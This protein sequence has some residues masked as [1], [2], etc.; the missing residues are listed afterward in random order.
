MT[1]TFN[2]NSDMPDLWRIE[3]IT[4][5]DGTDRTDGHY[6]SR[7]GCIVAILYIKIGRP[8]LWSYVAD[9][10]D[11]IR[12]GYRQS[13]IINHASYNPETQTLHAESLCS[14]Y[15]LKKLDQQWGDI[16]SDREIFLPDSYPN[17]LGAVP[18]EIDI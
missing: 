13:G 4:N 6:P 11:G 2:Q 3:R 18:M 14:R 8:L 15:F 7:I 5:H 10:N 9:S 17:G 1:Y 12:K 16:Y